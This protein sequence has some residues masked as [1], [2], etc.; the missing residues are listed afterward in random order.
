[1]NKKY[2][3]ILGLKPSQGARSP[4]L[5]NKVYKKISSVERMIPIDI[6]QK[7]FKKKFN[8]LKKD[9]NFL[10]GAVT[11]PYKEAC[12]KLLKTIKDKRILQIGA[13]NCLYRNEKGKLVG[14]NTDGEAAL[15]VFNNEIKKKKIKKLKTVAILGYGGVGKA[16]V[17]Y[18]SSYYKNSSII[19]PNEKELQ[20][21][22]KIEIKNENDV[23]E[24]CKNIISKHNINYV[25]AKRGKNGM[26][27]VGKNNFIEIIKAHSVVEPDVTGAG[28][29]VIAT[30][31]LAYSKTKD[32]AL[33]AKISNY[34]AS[35]AVSKLGT[36]NININDLNNY[37]G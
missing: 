9:K 28:D 15:E 21:C 36:A 6:P 22:S 2:T 5:W 18:F 34:A 4:K 37:I 29:T 20:K 30:L 27:V 32:I 12:F 19:T 31:S 7:N 26:I 16:I 13:V 14:T 10:G 8:S 33:S 25:V 35:I 24:A 17:A 23:I 1:M 3:A 11:V